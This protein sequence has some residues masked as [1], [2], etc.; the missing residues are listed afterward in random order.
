MVDCSACGKPIIDQAFVMA[1]REI[2]HLKCYPYFTQ[3]KK[4][5]FKED[6]LKWLTKVNELQKELS[7]CKQ[8]NNNYQDVCQKL[9]NTTNTYKEKLQLCDEYYKKVVEE[10]IQLKQQLEKLKA[11]YDDLQ[12]KYDKLL[13][14]ETIMSKELNAK[15]KAIIKSTPWETEDDSEEQG[16]SD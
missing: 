5:C 3:P 8:N 9:E 13:I 10:N 4:D 14:R 12:N 11:N 16:S 6:E 1:A 15:P 7:L 2:Y